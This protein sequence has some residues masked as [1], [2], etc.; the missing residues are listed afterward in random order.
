MSGKYWRRVGGTLLVLVMGVMLCA[1]TYPEPTSSFYVNDYAQVLSSETTTHILSQSI[2]L[3]EKTGAQLVVVTVASLDGEDPQSYA[4]HL[5]RQWK[6]G[7]GELDNGLLVLLALEEREVRVEV[8]RGLEGALNDA[9]VGRLLDQ[10][11]V[12]PFRKNDFDQGIRA[13]YDALL[14]EVL[15]EYGLDALPG[16]EQVQQEGTAFPVPLLLLVVI[17]VAFAVRGG[18]RGRPPRGGFYGGPFIGGGFG[19]GFRSG[20]FGGTGS[21]HLGGGGHFGGGGAGRKF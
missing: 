15:V 3:E 11:A 4:L 8:G 2:A 9:K 19:G 1:A 17:L 5:A 18:G 16:Y 6:I 20:G 21:G 10:Y 12:E 13:L 7:S 14:S